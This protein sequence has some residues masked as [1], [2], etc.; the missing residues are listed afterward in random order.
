MLLLSCIP[1][2]QRTPAPPRLRELSCGS[3]KALL[4]VN[5][6]KQGTHQHS[7]TSGFHIC[8]TA[9]STGAP[10]EQTRLVSEGKGVCF[11][12]GIKTVE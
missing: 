1:P 9:A 11:G 3:H 10:S 8:A 12:E 2:S 6:I 5:R 7:Q 4:P